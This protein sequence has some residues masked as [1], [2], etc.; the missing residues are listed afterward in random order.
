MKKT[1]VIYDKNNFTVDERIRK[2]FR[3]IKHK[4]I[5]E[6]N[7]PLNLENLFTVIFFAYEEE[8]IIAF[9]NYYKVTNNI[10]VCS[11][12]SNVLKKFKNFKDVNFFKLS[13]INKDIFK[14]LDI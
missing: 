5:E 2:N 9:L 12:Y 4:S 14:H 6:S 1:I 10:L 8:D 7:H 11:S 13:I 3:I